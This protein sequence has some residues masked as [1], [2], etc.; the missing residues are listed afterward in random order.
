M[1]KKFDPYAK[2]TF[3]AKQFIDTPQIKDRWQWYELAY[4]VHE[5]TTNP[6]VKLVCKFVACSFQGPAWCQ[7]NNHTYIKFD[8]ID[9]QIIREEYLRL[10]EK[11]VLV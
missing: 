9:K 3:T 10:K 4:R 11:G 1:S 6:D 5:A 7:E 2:D 8:E